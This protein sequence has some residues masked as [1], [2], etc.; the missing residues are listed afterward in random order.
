MHPLSFTTRLALHI[1][2]YVSRLSCK[3][4]VPHR[5]FT[6][7]TQS[8]P[9]FSR[10]SLRPRRLGGALPA[11]FRGVVLLLTLSACAETPRVTPTPATIRIATSSTLSLLLDDLGDL[12]GADHPWVT[13][14]SESLDSAAALDLL[15]GAVD[16]AFV[17]W[18][19]PDLGARLW[20]SPLAYDAVAVIVHPTNPLTGLSLAQLRDVFQGRV[21]D[22]SALGWTSESLIVV[23]REE[24]SGTRAAFE[25]A[26]MEGRPVT[27]NAI[28]QPGSEAMIDYVARTPGAIG[29]VSRGRATSAVKPIAIEGVDPSP[30]NVVNGTYPI[31]RVLY[32]AARSEPAGAVRDFVAWLLS[33]DGQQTIAERGFGRVK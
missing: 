29:Y 26:A 22:W 6:A 27:L 11:F 18:L 16:L 13:I 20:N 8:S 1:T 7:E 24:G 9:S 33:A 3:K 25:E 15:N 28:V 32:V 30:L 23:S 31:G 5:F 12:Y 19:P 17:S 4:V 21:V 2:F 14:Q 10:F